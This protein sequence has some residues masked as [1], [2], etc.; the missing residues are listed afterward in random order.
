MISAARGDGRR[1]WVDTSAPALAE[2]VDAGPVGIRIN[3]DEAAALLTGRP[4][5]L[6]ELIGAARA[7]AAR[8]DGPVAITDGAA[9]AVLVAGEGAW[10]VSPPHVSVVSAVG[11]GDCFLA[12]LMLG[13][14]EGV[15]PG[16]ALRRAAA[17][18]AA[19]AAQADAGAIDGAE[20]ARLTDRTRVVRLDG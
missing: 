3:A 13:M 19:N 20:V 11:S 7:I 16:A 18:G 9:P 2:A 12:G 14:A 10:Q 1:V 8:C 17:A 6:L 5:G 4:S 15:D